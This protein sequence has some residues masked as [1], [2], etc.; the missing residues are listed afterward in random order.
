M[1]DTA[2]PLPPPPPPP[3]GGGAMSCG[4]LMSSRCRGWMNAVSSLSISDTW[5]AW[6]S[7]NRPVTQTCVSM[8]CAW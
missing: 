5:C 8:A 4:V 6:G 1:R 7:G 2:L 3:A